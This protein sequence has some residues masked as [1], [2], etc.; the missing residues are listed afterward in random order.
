MR[1]RLENYIQA[2]KYDRKRKVGSEHQCNQVF[3]NAT[4]SILDEFR[5]EMAGVE[6]YE[7]D[8][9]VC[10]RVIRTCKTIQ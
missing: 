10:K 5:G 6:E 8:V 3:H 7:A 2:K 1:G 9:A 4:Q